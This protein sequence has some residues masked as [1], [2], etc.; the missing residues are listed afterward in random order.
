MV[1]KR[2]QAHVFCPLRILLSLHH[3]GLR[4]CGESTPSDDSEQIVFALLAF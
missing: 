4:H 1:E 2:W 3:C